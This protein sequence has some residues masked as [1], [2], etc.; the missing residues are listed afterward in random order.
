M[1]FL[2]TLTTDFRL[3][4]IAPLIRFKRATPKKLWSL[5]KRKGAV[6]DPLLSLLSTEKGHHHNVPRDSLVKALGSETKLDST[7]S[8]SNT[9][10]K[11][12]DL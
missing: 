7:Q 4:V 12:Y 11:T 2:P 8:W 9:L 1:Q 3:V 6:R 5:F 10:V